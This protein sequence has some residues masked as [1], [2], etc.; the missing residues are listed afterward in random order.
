MPRRVTGGGA[1]AGNRRDIRVQPDG[2]IGRSRQKSE[3]G[4]AC[5]LFLLELDGF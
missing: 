4:G 1:S 3:R 5:R 2:F